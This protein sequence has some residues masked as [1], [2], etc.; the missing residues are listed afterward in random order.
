MA[1]GANHHLYILDS[2]N[3]VY[4]GSAWHT[5]AN[6]T[7]QRDGGAAVATGGTIYYLGGRGPGNLA[8]DAVDVLTV[9]NDTWAAGPHLLSPTTSAAA[10]LDPNGRVFLM[11]GVT[12]GTVVDTTEVLD[13]G[14]WAMGD[15]LPQG[16]Y[17]ASA[18]TTADGNV[19]FLG[20]TIA[21]DA[22]DAVYVHCP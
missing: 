7:T 20:G 13:S 22:S 1:T 12:N 11:G 19:Y 5:I 9:L 4:D 16:K 18:A 17:N 15:P 21:G 10:A 3:E 8:V 14:S 6:P 2:L